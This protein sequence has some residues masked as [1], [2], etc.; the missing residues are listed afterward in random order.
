MNERGEAETSRSKRTS[1]RSLWSLPKRLSKVREG[2]HRIT[3][4]EELRRLEVQSLCNKY[5][6]R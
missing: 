4:S 2:H 5:G 6:G 1:K 3:L